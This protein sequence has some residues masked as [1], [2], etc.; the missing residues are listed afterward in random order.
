MRRNALISIMVSVFIFALFV[1]TAFAGAWTVPKHKVWGEYYIKWNYAKEDFNA[2]WGKKK[3][4]NDARSWE[5]IME[6]KLEF[7]VTDWLTA[8]GSIEYK[9]SHYKEYGRPVDWGTFVRKNHG[10]TNYKFGGRLRFLDEPVVMSIQ[11]KYYLSGEY[12]IDHGDSSFNA[13]QPSIGYGN[14]SFELRYLAGTTRNFQI[15]EKY[16]LPAYVSAET[17]YIWNNRH[18]A[19]GY[20]YFI[21]GGVWPIQTILLKTELDGYK[22]HD[23]TGSLKEEAYGIWRIGGAWQIFGDSVLRQDNKLFNIEFQYGMTVYGK[24]TTAFQEWV[25]KVDTQF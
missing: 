15:T 9:E 11:G 5:F 16:V 3:K 4:N 23:G 7:G 14:D 21:E 2:T 22:S 19:N 1:E 18:V 10:I 17:G 20:Q 8:L 6:P 24:N 12:P 25:V 13:G